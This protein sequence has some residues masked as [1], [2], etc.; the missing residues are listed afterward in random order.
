LCLGPHGTAPFGST[1]YYIRDRQRAYEFTE[2][3]APGTFR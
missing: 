2:T 1:G 3:R